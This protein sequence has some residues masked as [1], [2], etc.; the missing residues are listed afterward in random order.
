MF[1]LCT[2]CNKLADRSR[3][4]RIGFWLLCLQFGLG[5]IRAGKCLSD[6]VVD[7]LGIDVLA[8]EVDGKPRALGRAAD[9][10]A[11]ALVAHLD[12]VSAIAGSHGLL[13]GL[14]FLA[15]DFFAYVAH[16]LAFIGLRRIV[17]P[18]VG[19]HLTNHFLVDPFDANL[20]LVGHCNRYAIRN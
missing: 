15:D 8:T 16:S 3:R 14:A 7:H 17:S 2:L 18:D 6:S 4:G 11:Y 12:I 1:R 19:G 20:G 5:R 10:F 9:D 13:D